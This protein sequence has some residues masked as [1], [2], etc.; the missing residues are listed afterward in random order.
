[1]PGY[2]TYKRVRDA[3][4]QFLIDHHVTS[5]PIVFSGICRNMEIDLLTYDGQFFEADER[6]VAC[7]KNNRR[8]ILINSSDSRE[9][10]RYT[11]GHELGHIYLGHVADDQIHTRL[12]GTRAEPKPREEY[13]AERFAMDILAPAC[14]LYGLG[15]RSAEDIARVCGIPIEEARIRAERMRVLYERDAF[16]ESPLEMK[17]FEQFRGFI[18]SYLASNGF[19]GSAVL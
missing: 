1:M 14:V 15:I 13:E 3:A 4:W 19:E 5:L 2:V 9:V 12:T 7:T 17:V 8:I 11:I 10:Q 18:R 16:F 6:G